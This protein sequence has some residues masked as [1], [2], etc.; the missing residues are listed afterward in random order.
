MS[1]NRL[2]ISNLFIVTLVAASGAFAGPGGNGKGNGGGGGGGGGSPPPDPVCTGSEPKEPTIAYLTAEDSSG[3]T[4]TKDLYLS[5]DS[6]CDRYLLLENVDEK[7]SSGECI[8]CTLWLSFAT[9]GNMGVV[10]WANYDGFSRAQLGVQFEFDSAGNVTPLSGFPQLFHLS[11]DG[12]EPWGPDVRFNA[13]GEVELAFLDRDPT[14]IDRRLVVYNVTTGAREE[15]LSFGCVIPNDAG[16]CFEV[17]WPVFWS[18]NSDELYISVIEPVSNPTPGN[19]SRGLA[20]VLKSSGGWAQPELLMVNEG[21]VKFESVSSNGD[22]VYDYEEVLYTNR[23]KVKGIRRAFGV[24]DETACDLSVCSPFDGHDLAIER[25]GKGDLVL[26]PDGRALAFISSR[27]GE[28]YV[29]EY[30][31]PFTSETGR[32]LIEGVGYEFDTAY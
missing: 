16:T 10:S 5:S 4:I 18:Q 23:G 26:T 19:H 22:L 11:E 2:F 24:I 28:G 20:R 8:D 25:N 9:Q 6:G 7:L 17:T 1:I 31:E 12:F 15:V 27:G 32:R 29:Q 3:A 21:S 14:T 30:L 13:S